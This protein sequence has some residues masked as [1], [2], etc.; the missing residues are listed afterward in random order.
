MT[1]QG[2]IFQTAIGVSFG[3][4]LLVLSACCYCNNIIFTRHKINQVEEQSYTK[5]SN[6][7]VRHCR[8]DENHIFRS[9]HQR[10]D[11]DSK[12]AMP[13]HKYID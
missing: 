7:R 4:L 6:D 13:T 9:L 2:R 12:S 5:S 8:I 11:Q 1:R 10:H 3:L